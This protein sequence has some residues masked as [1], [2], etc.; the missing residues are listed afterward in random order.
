MSHIA[1][2][3]N[4]SLKVKSKSTSEISSRLIVRGSKRQLS[5]RAKSRK[6]QSEESPREIIQ[7]NQKVKTKSS[8]RKFVQ[9]KCT[10]PFPNWT[11]DDLCEWL[12]SNDLDHENMLAIQFRS[13]QLSGSQLIVPDLAWEKMNSYKYKSE[14]HK[15]EVLIKLAECISEANEANMKKSASCDHLRQCS[16][17]HLRASPAL[18]YSNESLLSSSDY[19]S[20]SSASSTAL[21]SLEM[22]CF[23]GEMSLTPTSCV[24]Q[25]Q[26][27]LSKSS[28]NLKSLVNKLKPN[29]KTDDKASS[30]LRSITLYLDVDSPGKKIVK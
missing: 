2:R 7:S 30:N 19:V 4:G 25:Q 11:T 10:R 28:P 22:E 29:F 13:T 14:K 3:E 15:Q 12:R 8:M 27:K 26:H 20:G 23:N 18:S 21:A 5:D 6:I 24:P 17:R 9:T 16:N 1:G